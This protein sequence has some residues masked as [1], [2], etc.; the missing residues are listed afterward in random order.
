MVSARSGLMNQIHANPCIPIDMIVYGLVPRP[1]S[2]LRK[3]R[4]SLVDEKP[5]ANDFVVPRDINGEARKAS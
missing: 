2:G 4:S 3:D 1:P 5:F